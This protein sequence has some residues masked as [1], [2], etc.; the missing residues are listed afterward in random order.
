M[1]FFTVSCLRRGIV[2]VDGL[3]QGENKTGE[4]L[5]VFQCQAGLHDVS[6]ECRLG[7]R[8]LEMTQRVMISGTNAILPVTVRFVC[9]LQDEPGEQ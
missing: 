3:Y 8:C 5:R 6:L 2:R 4:T 9:E 1:E 7:R